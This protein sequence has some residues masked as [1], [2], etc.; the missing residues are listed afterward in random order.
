MLSRPGQHLR[1]GVA[2]DGVAVARTGT[3]GSRRAQ[4]I[5]ERRIA[6]T[7]LLDEILAALRELL[8]AAPPGGANV[9]IVLADELVRMWPVAPPPACARMSDLRAAAAM[10]FQALFG[11]P[12]AGWRI[13]AD[14]DAAKPF[15]AVAVR[16]ELVAQ[17]EKIVCEERGHV[18]EVVPQFVVSLRRWRAL[19]RPGAWLGVVQSHVLT[20]ALFD[21]ADL[22]AVCSTAV[23]QGA[24]REWLDSHVARESL[25]LGLQRPERVQLLGPAPKSWA[26]QAGRAKSGYSLLDL[27]DAAPLSDL[28][29]LVCTGGETRNKLT[30]FAS[31]SLRRTVHCTSTPARALVLAAL[32]LAP[33]LAVGFGHYLDALQR[34]EA[35]LASQR[36]RQQ[37]P[38]ARKAVMH[39]Q[40]LPEKAVAVNAAIM[41]LNLPWRG[42]HDAVQEA[43]PPTVALLSLEPDPKKRVLHISA[44]AKGSA[45]MIGYVERMKAQDWFANVTLTRHEIDDQDQ[46]HPVRFQLDAQWRQP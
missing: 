5:A 29:R 35:R 27:E 6:P 25:R 44:E 43:T 41:Q 39:D 3:W 22:A 19:R 1:I 40:L 45:D 23:P 11:S 34:Y 8:A 46:N 36:A 9:S 4:L 33:A 38:A 31:P 15:L 10:R 12:P 16:E 7:G 42:L 13:A 28:A 24:G 32:V 2:S 30:N 37:Q 26:S 21:G 17:I 20:L 14:W 18:V